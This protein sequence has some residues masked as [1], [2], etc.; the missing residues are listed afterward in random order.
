LQPKDQNGHEK[1]AREKY[2]LFRPQRK[3]IQRIFRRYPKSLSTRLDAAIDLYDEEGDIFKA[4][5][6]E[7]PEG[8]TLLE[9]GGVQQI[10]GSMAEVAKLAPAKATIE[11]LIALGNLEVE[12][13]AYEASTARHIYRAINVGFIL[14]QKSARVALKKNWLEKDIAPV[15]ELRDRLAVRATR[16]IDRIKEEIIPVEQKIFAKQILQLAS[17]AKVH[18]SGVF[19]SDPALAPA[20]KSE[21][22]IAEKARLARDILKRVGAKELDNPEFARV[23][24]QL[25]STNLTAAERAKLEADRQARSAGLSRQITV[26]KDVLRGGA[27]LTEGRRDKQQL[28][29]KID[30]LH[31]LTDEENQRLLEPDERGIIVATLVGQLESFI[32][33]IRRVKGSSDEEVQ[34]IAR[35]RPDVMKELYEFDLDAAF[36][37]L[38]GLLENPEIARQ[39]GQALDYDEIQKIRLAVENYPAPHSESSA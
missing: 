24:N 22:Y 5:L 6:A 18:L 8:G 19:E 28:S 9:S 10:L 37:K 33:T 30:L 25:A 26:A 34:T 20:A 12:L 29:E 35:T 11:S 4:T 16:R 13:V 17:E 7:L 15:G 21:A 27:R 23:V 32:K 1:P 36:I 3:A 31:S 14:P 2:K 38:G 39:I